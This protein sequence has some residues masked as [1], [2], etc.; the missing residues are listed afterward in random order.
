MPDEVRISQP[1]PGSCVALTSFTV[2]GDFE[3]DSENATK[4]DGYEV[5]VRVKKENGDV[6]AAYQQATK[7]GTNWT[8][9]FMI[10]G[11]TEYPDATIEAQLRLNNTPKD[12]DAVDEVDIQVTCSGNPTLFP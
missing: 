7:T 4:T 10:G 12:N 6:V 8:S 9:T 1:T 5:Y 11:S 2:S 3:T